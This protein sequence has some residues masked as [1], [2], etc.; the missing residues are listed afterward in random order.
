MVGVFLSTSIPSRYGEQNA[1]WIAYLLQCDAAALTQGMLFRESLI[2][3]ETFAVPLSRAQALDAVDSLARQ[4]RVREN[5]DE[6]G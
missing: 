1:Q 3:G 5:R 2:N 4:V 6:I